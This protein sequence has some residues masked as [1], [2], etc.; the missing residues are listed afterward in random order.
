MCVCTFEYC[1]VTGIFLL[2]VYV[3]ISTVAKLGSNWEN[4]RNVEV[5]WVRV[6]T[7][8]VERKNKINKLKNKKI[9]KKSHKIKERKI[10]WD[11]MTQK[12][13]GKESQL[14]FSSL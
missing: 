2:S 13:I 10:E 3:V 4:R 9:G 1:I 6:S 11:R 7:E 14:A 12:H 8:D 5:K